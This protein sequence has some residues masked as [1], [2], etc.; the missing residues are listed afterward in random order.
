MKTEFIDVKEEYD[1]L[2]SRD[3]EA[4]PRVGE[5]VMNL[6]EA[7]DVDEWSMGEQHEAK[8]LHRR[9]Y[10][11]LAVEHLFRTMRRNHTEHWCSVTVEEVK[12]GEGVSE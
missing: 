1:V 7:D 2:F 3:C 12:R 11:V 6:F 4:V 5:T 10:R 8:H 9:Q